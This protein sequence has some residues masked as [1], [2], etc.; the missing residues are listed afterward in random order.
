MLGLGG[1]ERRLALGKLGGRENRHHSIVVAGWNGIELMVMALGALHGMGEK[2]LAHRVG[3]VVQPH[4]A[5]FLEY[6]H[7]RLFP[8]A[9]AQKSY[10]HKV[11]GIIRIHLVP[12]DLFLHETVVRFVTV[13]GAHDVVTVTPGI[14]A[15]VVVGKPGGVGIARNVQPMPRE[16]FPVM[17][18]GHQ[19]FDMTKERVL[20]FSQLALKLGCRDRI[21][22]QPGQSEGQA[23]IQCAGGCIRSRIKPGFLEFTVHEPVDRVFARRHVLNLKRPVGPKFPCLV[24]TLLPFLGQGLGGSHLFALG[25]FLLDA[26]Y[27]ILARPRRSL[28]DPVANRPSL[29]PGQLVRFLGGHLH[30]LL[31]PGG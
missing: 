19:L 4:L 13:E 25:V 17:R 29:F 18:S 15:G 21:R 1:K 20:G 28:V 31:H 2:G 11:L 16:M 23:T 10:S 26:G 7:A 12:R 3:H 8:W 30:V 22:R 5:G 24:A 6:A 9:H 27:A 14:G